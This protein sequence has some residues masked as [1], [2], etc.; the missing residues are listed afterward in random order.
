MEGLGFAN[1]IYEP[2]VETAA[3]KHLKR[4]ILDHKAPG[5]EMRTDRWSGYKVQEANSQTW[6]GRNR[7]RRGRTSPS[8]IER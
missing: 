4:F 7:K 3:R 5:A 6:L 2:V 1:S 8:S